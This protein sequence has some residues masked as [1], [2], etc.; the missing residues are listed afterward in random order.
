[1]EPDLTAVPEF[2]RVQSRE[3]R[4]RNELG[5]RRCWNL[6]W[7]ILTGGVN[8]SDNL[9]RIHRQEPGSFQGTFESFLESVYIEDRDRVFKGYSSG[10]R[11]GRETTTSNIAAGKT[12]TK[13]LWFEARGRVY[14]AIQ[15]SRP[16]MLGVC[17]DIT[18]RKTFQQQLRQSQKMESLGVL[19]G[20]VAHGF[21]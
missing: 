15:D 18:E 17:M 3:E 7:N 11:K 13:K 10:N 19:A 16:W 6:E 20:G 8:W 14:T 21:Q 5:C 12:V 4:L 9:E 2:R 1:M